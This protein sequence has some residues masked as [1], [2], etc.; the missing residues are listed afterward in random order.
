MIEDFK[1]YTFAG[2]FLSGNGTVSSGNITEKYVEYL[3]Y[4]VQFGRR[5]R[6]VIIDL[7]NGTTSIVARKIFEK[8]M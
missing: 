1:N 4:G 3:R 6:K 8:S 5:K 2:K 7:G